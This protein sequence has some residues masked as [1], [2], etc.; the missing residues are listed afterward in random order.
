MLY[1]VAGTIIARATLAAT[2]AMRHFPPRRPN[3]PCSPSLDASLRATDRRGQNKNNVWTENWTGGRDFGKVCGWNEQVWEVGTE[4]APSSR[5]DLSMRSRT[6]TE[7][8]FELRMA[9]VCL[10]DISEQILTY[11]WTRCFQATECDGGCEADQC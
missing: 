2:K 7:A 5:F 6:Y 8:Y 4:C 11:E 1:V 10:R 3:G 9:C